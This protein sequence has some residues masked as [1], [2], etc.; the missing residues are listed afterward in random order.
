MTHDDMRDN[1]FV[2]EPANRLADCVIIR[3]IIGKGAKSA[4]AVQSIA[5]HRNGCPEAGLC[6]A[7]AKRHCNQWKEMHVD[8]SGG[9]PRPDARATDTVI[10]AGHGAD[11]RPLQMTDD[12]G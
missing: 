5:S 4:D 10:E 7:E 9:E 12:V 1:D 11:I 8:G 3:Q 6:Q 2:T